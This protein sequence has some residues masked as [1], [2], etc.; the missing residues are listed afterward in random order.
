MANVVQAS[1]TEKME[2]EPTP[3]SIGVGDTVVWTNNHVMSHTVTADDQTWEPFDSGTLARGQAFEYTF[4]RA[5]TYPYHCAFHP[6]MK[7]VVTVS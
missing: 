7:G 6:H 4:I 2:Y 5:G 3:V 1:I